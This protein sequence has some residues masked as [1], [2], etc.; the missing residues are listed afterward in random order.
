MQSEKINREW[1]RA[2]GWTISQAAKALK[3]SRN[4]VATVLRGERH[5]AALER[6]LR[7]LPL[8]TPRWREPLTH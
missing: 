2:R 6:K 1:L 4:H 3:R 5:S 8:R 7:E